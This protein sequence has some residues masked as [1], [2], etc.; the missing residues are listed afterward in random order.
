M[1][2]YIKKVGLKDN[3][4]RI[5]LIPGISFYAFVLYTF[6]LMFDTS[7][8]AFLISSSLVTGIGIVTLVYLSSDLIKMWLT[9]SNYYIKC[10][11]CN[12]KIRKISVTTGLYKNNYICMHCN[13]VWGE[14]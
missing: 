4:L 14:K 7:T 11:G 6:V 3:L 13:E 5:F 1:N 12:K 10:P 2:V 8:A 9:P